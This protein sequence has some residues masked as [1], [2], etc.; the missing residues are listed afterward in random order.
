MSF[1]PAFD[2]KEQVRQ[3]IDI[4]DLVG[5]YVQLRRQ[6][7]NFVG[8]CPWH[9]D[10]RPS[11]QVNPERQSFKCWVCD[12]R[13]RRVQLRH[14]GRRTWSSAKRWNCWPSGPAFSCSRPR[15]RQRAGRSSRRRPEDDKRTL[16]P[17]HGLGRRAISSLPAST[18]RKPSPAARILPSAASRRKRSAASISAS[19]PN[20]WDWL[21][22]RARG[23]EW[24]PAIARTRRPVAAQG[25]RRRLLRLVPR[26]RDVLDS[27]RPLAA[28]RVRRP[29][30]AT[31]SGRA[32]RPN[33][34]TRPRR[35][36]S[37]RAASCTASM[38][39]ANNFKADGGAIVMEGYTD[40]LMAHQHGIDNC[41]AV[42]GTAL[43]ERHLQ[44]LRRYTDSITLVL[45]GDDAGRR[46]TNEILDALLALFEKN[47][48][49]LRILTLPEGVDPCDFI[50]THGSDAFRQL[51]ARRSTRWNTNSKR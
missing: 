10:S 46:R 32:H 29:R 34:S 33:T 13:R 41:V 19:R 27:R 20:R 37:P 21:L 40:C 35:R 6:G 51:L 17:R 30:A 22:E 25:A 2:A 45:D 42:L 4:V 5:S 31:A 36:C 26:P 8:L 7:R 44:L 23:S 39:P 12:Y 47:Q 16:L 18:R 11:L 50:A 24:T 28:D 3:A 43:G 38:W 15:A 9:D 48:I 49:D 14:E 1:G